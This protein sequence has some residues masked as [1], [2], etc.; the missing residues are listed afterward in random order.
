MFSYLTR[1]LYRLHSQPVRVVALSALVVVILAVILFNVVGWL[2]RRRQDRPEHG[3]ALIT[4]A[5]G[6]VLKVL[7]GLA[8]VAAAALHLS[9]QS[10][11]FAR[12]HGG[13]TQRCYEAVKT[14]WGRPHTQKELRVRLI[15]YTTHIYDKDGMEVDPE[16]LK[17]STQP[18]GFRKAKVEHTVPGNP[19]IEADH[20][21]DLWMNYRKKGGAYYPCFETN[22]RFTYRIVNFSDQKASVQ[23]NFPLPE[24]QGLIDNLKVTLDGKEPHK[25]L[26]VTGDMAQWWSEMTPGQKHDVIVSYHSRGLDHLR[27]EPGSGRQLR[28]YRI[29][30]KCT[31]I[32]KNDLNY[33]IGCMT[34]MTI[35]E[36]QVDLGQD[37]Q[38]MKTVPETTLL[39][40]LDSAVTRLG[41]G[42]IVPA[43]KQE[44]YYVARALAAAP[45]GLVLLLAMVIITH[46]AT[47]QGT[48]WLA[49][50]LL[51]V[52]YHLYYLLMAHIGDYAPGLI[53][54]MLISG[55]ALTALIALLEFT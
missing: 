35:E 1:Y 15:Y 53:G 4:G 27:F 40:Q 29:R 41:M 11:E 23:F 20:S 13:I 50:L 38:N 51:A 52:G 25:P 7:I 39:W 12:L 45:W 18:I 24:R 48:R 21:I 22:C 32:A 6:A 31:G 47:G 17:A 9:F 37:P 14:I 33:P 16:K 5:I 28:K 10:K 54:G 43:K 34:P 42:V 26:V 55:A 30:M 2:R 8:I 44:G 46:M 19:I 36:S 49:L 3:T